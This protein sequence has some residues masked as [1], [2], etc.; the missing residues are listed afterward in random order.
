MF[1]TRPSSSGS[2]VG[3]VLSL[4]RATTLVRAAGP[5]VPL[6]SR[7]ALMGPSALCP[8][9]G[10]DDAQTMKTKENAP[11]SRILVGVD[12]SP[13]SIDALRYARRLAEALDEPLEVITTWDL[14]A[15]LGYGNYLFDER[16]L[17]ERAQ[18]VVRNAIAD[19]FAGAPP[20]KVSTL[21]KRGPAARTLIEQ[22]ASAAMLVLGS[23]GHGGFV[24]MV[25]GSVSAAC[26][27][28]ADCPVVIFHAPKDGVVQ[29]AHDRTTVG[30]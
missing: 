29:P 10:A 15:Q 1:D 22:S 18:A 9:A 25:L 6:G 14:P 24:G 7:P 3:L 30:D 13:S 17:V 16:A 5:K 4:N 21:V 12:G 11:S 27:A 28:H 2:P 26:A 19:A 8:R 23:R 20:G